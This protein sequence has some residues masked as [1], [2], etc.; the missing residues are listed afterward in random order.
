V[1]AAVVFLNLPKALIVALTAGAGASIILSGILL[2]LGR[3]SL[4]ALTWG[5]VGAFIRASWFWFLV[6][7]V[8]AGAGIAAQLLLPEEYTLA[9]YGTEELGSPPPMRRQLAT[10]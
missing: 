8:L 10:G 3:I 5:V 4:A 2:A 6:F 9:P 7:L 1:V